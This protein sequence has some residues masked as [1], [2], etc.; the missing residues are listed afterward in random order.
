MAAVML[1]EGDTSIL[2]IEYA[3]TTHGLLLKPVSDQ[4]IQTGGAPFHL[5]KEHDCKLII[6]TKLT[7]LEDKP[8]S[9][10]VA[11][12]GKII[13]NHPQSII[14]NNTSDHR[15]PEMSNL[16]FKKIYPKTKFLSWHI[17]SVYQLILN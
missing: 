17:T 8:M 1:A 5:L 9:H 15:N 12:E 2:I 10:F 4:Y 6:N 11:W 7:N 13:T 16:F 3:L 14:V